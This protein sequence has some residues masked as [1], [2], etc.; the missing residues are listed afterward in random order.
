MS[1]GERDETINELARAHRASLERFAVSLN[2]VDAGAAVS[3]AFLALFDAWPLK[4]IDAALSW[5]V[6]T[7][8]NGVL[9]QHRRR[10]YEDI[11]AAERMK[12]D[13]ATAPSAEQEAIR[14]LGTEEMRKLIMQ[15]PPRQ[16]DVIELRWLHGWTTKEIAERLGIVAGTVRKTDHDALANLRKM[17]GESE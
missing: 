10:K 8:R 12:S 13:T 4:H 11:A 6:T 14:R 2:A 7:V 5:L 3:D 15:L 17:L 16:R 9:R 1:D